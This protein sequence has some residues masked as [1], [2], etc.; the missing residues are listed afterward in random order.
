M[1]PILSSSKEPQ[2]TGTATSISGEGKKAPGVPF[3]KRNY[4]ETM[5]LQWLQ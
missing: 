4:G 2:A 5:K 1:R 3:C